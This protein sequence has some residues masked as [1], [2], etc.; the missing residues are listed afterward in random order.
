MAPP[1]PLRRVS[2]GSLS[3]LARSQDRAHA[4]PSGLDFLQPALTD[5]VDEAA[6]LGANVANLTALHHAL[7]T[8]N[9]SFASYLYALKMNAFC[10]EWPEAPD[11][12]SFA[13]VA[14]LLP[15][16]DPEPLPLPSP[17]S[18][19]AHAR[20]PSPPSAASAADMT[21]ATMYSSVDEMAA[22]APSAPSAP[23]GILK[24]PAGGSGSGV[25]AGA[26][27]GVGVV[28]AATVARG[29]TSAA[30]KKKRELEVASHIDTLPLEFRGNDPAARLA[31]AKV[32]G[33]LM[34]NPSGLTLKEVVSSPD[35]PQPRAN[36]CLIALVAKKL[37]V[38]VNV[39]GTASY[40]WVGA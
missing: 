13:S 39:R 30:M 25:G 37:V 14:S 9:E 27:A 24:K 32:I 28:P 15:P 12:N 29:K 40:R 33:T 5:L 21:Y 20:P 18:D 17:A 16:P 1:H 8:F 19:R 23:R 10:V 4:S 22:P 34:D 6:T 3:S 38:K 2:T 36:K 7:G 26:G 11:V 35:V 31:M